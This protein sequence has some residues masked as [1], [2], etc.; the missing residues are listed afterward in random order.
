ML[1]ITNNS[2][3]NFLQKLKQKLM[4]LGIASWL[5][6]FIFLGLTFYVLKFLAS[7]TL[8]FICLFLDFIAFT[9]IFTTITLGVLI[10][11]KKRQKKD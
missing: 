4:I 10:F 9:G 11:I 7:T 6:G 8:F 1:P 5:L 3:V 2:A